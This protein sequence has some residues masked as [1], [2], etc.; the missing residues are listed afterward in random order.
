MQILFSFIISLFIGLLIGIEREHSHQE[1]AEPIGVRTFI[2]FALL[3]TLAATLHEILLTYLISLF[4]FSLI[5]LGYFQ[6][7]K[8]GRKKIDAG[9]TT[10]I[11]AGIV[12]CIGYMVPSAHLMAIAI[13]AL[14]L[15]VLVERQRLHILARKKFKAHTIETAIIFIIFTLGVLPIL[16][17]HVVDRWGLFNPHNFGILLVTIAGI[18]FI[19]YVLI[20]LFGESFGM[21]VT[22]LLGGFVSSTI[23]YAH[24]PHL[25]KEHPKFVPAIMASAIC[26]NLAMLIEV[27]AIIFV[28]SPD[29]FLFIMKPIVAMV[30]ISIIFIA[31]LLYFQKLKKHRAASIANPFSW[32]S[33]FRTA[34][35]I[36]LI[37]PIIAIAKHMAGPN[38]I[39]ILSF[40]SGLIELH[41]ITLATALL[42]LNHQLSS[43]YA[44]SILYTSILATYISK[45][46]LL[47]IG[48]PKKFALHMSFFLM[49]ILIS[50][51]VTFWMVYQ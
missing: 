43:S 19:G 38:G 9:I 20:R 15:L 6:S 3:G 4:V 7:T 50:G 10:E 47:W 21:A 42:Y 14:V 8:E 23:V 32:A 46:I 18:Q 16:P 12:F 48:T 41:G 13:S 28:A 45:F 25:L 51:G 44:N 27:S 5:L 17:D 33:L 1:N 40:F 22:G 35:F 26:A 49:G 2:L 36:G 30:V 11:S 29:L 24:L 37:L 34:L 39:L 31:Y